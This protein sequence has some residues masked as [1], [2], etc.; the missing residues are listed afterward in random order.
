MDENIL[1]YFW[2]FF[3]SSSAYFHLI[4]LSLSYETK[5]KIKL[6]KKNLTNKRKY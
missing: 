4:V 2:V 3:F 1:V 6:K 5:Q